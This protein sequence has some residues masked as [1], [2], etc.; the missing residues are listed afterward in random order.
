VCVPPIPVFS[1]AVV[2]CGSGNVLQKPHC[3]AFN[4]MNGLKDAAEN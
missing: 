4:E 2:V 1:F 3:V